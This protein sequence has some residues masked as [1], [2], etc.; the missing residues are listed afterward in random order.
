MSEYKILVI[1]F[2]VTARILSQYVNIV[3]YVRFIVT[4]T[5]KPDPVII[6]VV[7]LTYVVLY[8]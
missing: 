6:T 2:Q 7:V 1:T 4:V 8:S 5:Y 3:I